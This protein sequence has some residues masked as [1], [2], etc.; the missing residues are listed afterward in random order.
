MKLIFQRV[1]TCRHSANV[2]ICLETAHSGRYQQA[3]I[4]EGMFHIE[5]MALKK[6]S[7]LPVTRAT[8][9]I[10]LKAV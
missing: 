6:K 10:S 3:A 2:L 4:P 8:Q 5:S 7:W 1:K 9:N